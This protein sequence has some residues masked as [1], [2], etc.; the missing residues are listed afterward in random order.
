MITPQRDRDVYLLTVGVCVCVHEDMRA[1]ASGALCCETGGSQTHA[2]WTEVEAGSSSRPTLVL[3]VQPAF[4]GAIGADQ[5]RQGV[6]FQLHRRA[7]VTFSG[8]ERPR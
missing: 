4:P 8:T 5:G 7:P 2:G 1:E 3:D 6:E